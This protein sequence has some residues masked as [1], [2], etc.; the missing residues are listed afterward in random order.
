[1]RRHDL[2]PW[3]RRGGN[4][5]VFCLA[6]RFS[7]ET[8]TRLRELAAAWA[9]VNVTERASFQ[10]WML[11]FCEALGVDTPD[12][13]TDAYRF[14]LP[15]AVVD[16]EGRESPNYIDCWKAGHFALEAKA[17]GVDLRNDALLRKA[18]GQVRN[19]VAHVSGCLLYT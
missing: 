14:E 18:F 17:S 8:P 11:R 4:S 9:D 13:P 15:I 5:G 6:M 2:G 7:S 1:M 19:Y 3:R 12:P 16:R 10:T